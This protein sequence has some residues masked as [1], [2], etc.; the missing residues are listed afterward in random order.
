MHSFESE[1]EQKLHRATEVY[2]KY[3]RKDYENKM[4]AAVDRI[5]LNKYDPKAFAELKE[6]QMSFDDKVIR[7]CCN[8]CR[9]CYRECTGSKNSAR[10]E[11]MLDIIEKRRPL[12]FDFREIPLSTSH[13][14]SR[15]NLN[16]LS[17][18][19]NNPNISPKFYDWSKE[20][21]CESEEEISESEDEISLD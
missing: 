17:W 2:E 6:M 9:D 20:P 18:L 16:F 4:R 11:K 10:N 1:D 12:L 19:K 8:H 15:A 7:H 13:D 21:P 5:V 14:M 3:F